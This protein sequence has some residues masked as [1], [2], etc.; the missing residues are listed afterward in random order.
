M[1]ICNS[2]PDS[3]NEEVKEEND[4]E[5]DNFSIG[6]SEDDDD[7][8]N[9]NNNSESDDEQLD[10]GD[11]SNDCVSVKIEADIMD[12]DLED[13]I[14]KEPGYLWNEAEFKH[15]IESDGLEADYNSRDG[16]KTDLGTKK[17]LSREN[18]DNSY[19]NDNPMT[20]SSA[21]K[22]KARSR[23]LQP[24]K[25][26]KTS[27][28]C[29]TCL[30]FYA[31][32]NL[33]QHV[34]TQHLNIRFPCSLCSYAADSKFRLKKHV[35]FRHSEKG[36]VPKEK[37]L[38]CDIAGCHFKTHS[39]EY[40]RTHKITHQEKKH[41][42]S[43][44]GATFHFKCGLDAHSAIHRDEKNFACD[45]PACHFV[46]K[47]KGQLAKHAVRHKEKRVSCDI[48][49]KK[50]F[51]TL[52]MK[53]HQISHQTEKNFH[54]LFPDCDFAT[55]RPDQLRNHEKQHGEKTETCHICGKTF[56]TQRSLAGHMLC[57][58]KSFQCALVN[59]RSFFTTQ[60]ALAAH[61][62][63]HRGRD[64]DCAV[65]GADFYYNSELQK[66]MRS[67]LG[68][69]PCVCDF[70]GCNFATTTPDL[71]KNH[72]RMHRE[73]EFPCGTCGKKFKSKREV[74]YHQKTHLAK[75]FVCG[76]PDCEFATKTEQKL[77]S[78][79]NNVH[80]E[81]KF[82][83]QKCDA[84]FASRTNWNEHQKYKHAREEATLEARKA[85][86]QASLFPCDFPSCLFGTHTLKLL[87]HHKLSHG[88]KTEGCQI[89]NE[90]FKTKNNLRGHLKSAHGLT[91]ATLKV[92]LAS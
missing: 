19:D 8:N 67:H 80:G 27:V 43:T 68:E 20:E 7:T 83:C 16:S 21:R 28:Q 89:C 12:L 73:K 35:T 9:I 49:D 60:E 85:A 40:L 65:C 63:E 53:N 37:T 6:S 88:E 81:K 86:H 39:R 90:M 33:Q 62:S 59:C 32:D 74:S 61:V 52:E 54:C 34:R 42:C 22:R 82:P 72:Q 91:F 57:H 47:T 3:L 5:V 29:E 75:N 77:K 78:H 10:T 55:K 31:K 70:P 25:R 4:S 87:K 58:D 79:Q 76:V 1:V 71:L 45:F 2:R 50:F 84:K 41:A 13:E 92:Y 15:K 14:K 38:S 30:R 66:H 24:R 48:C 56:H 36:L 69:K 46:T 51:T 23:N 64:F 44:C 26:P 17:V 18:K 11:G